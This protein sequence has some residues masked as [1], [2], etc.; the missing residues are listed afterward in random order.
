MIE[1]VAEQRKGL[2]DLV[3]GD[4]NVYPAWD[5]LLSGLLDVVFKKG[6]SELNLERISILDHESYE[7][8]L[9][10]NCDGFDGK[11]GVHKDNVGVI[12]FCLASDSGYC[13]SVETDTDFSKWGQCISVSEGGSLRLWYGRKCGVDTGLKVLRL[14]DMLCAREAEADVECEA[15]VEL[16][17]GVFEDEVTGRILSLIQSLPTV[18]NSSKD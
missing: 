3:V 7:A 8:A 15:D 18:R 1:S 4:C 16:V 13:T 6:G 5:K 14:K 17:E 12:H 11:L 9:L 10:S 2:V